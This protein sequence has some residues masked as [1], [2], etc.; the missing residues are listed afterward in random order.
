MALDGIVVADLVSELKSKLV[1]GRIM[2]ISQPER[3]ELVLTIKN[4]EQYKL[5]LSAGAGLP[6]VYITEESKPSPLQAP[7]F[8][9]LLRKYLNSARIMDIYQPGLERIIN[10][11]IEHLDELSDVKEKLLVIELMGKHSNIIFVDDQGK[12]VDSIK[13]VSGFVSSQRE[14]LPGREYF[15]VET[16]KKLDMAA[17]SFEEF[18]SSF[19]AM[20]QP[21]GKALVNCFTG[22]S[23]AVAAEIAYRADIDADD[24]VASLSP[25]ARIHLFKT[26]KFVS[27]DIAAG[28]FFTQIIYKDGVPVDFS[29]V[30]MT[31]MNC[32]GYEK[33]ILDSPSKM[34]HKFYAKKDTTVRIR[35]K[36]SDLRRII[37][38]AIERAAKKYDIQSK[39]LK[40][41]EKRDKYKEYGELLTTYGYSALPG[42]KKLV[43]TSFYTGEEVSI[44]LDETLSAI[45]NA[46]RY[47]D[48]YSKQKRT[49]EATSRMI[50]VTKEEMEHLDSIRTALDIALSEEDLAEIK[51]ELIDF[52]YMKR[53]ILPGKKG[54]K[55]VKITSKPFHF[56]S[57]DGFD[58]YVGKNNYQNEELTFKF[59]KGGDMWFHAKGIPGSHVVVRTDGSELPDRAYEEAGR[60]AAYFSKGRDAEKVEIDYLERKNVKKPSGSKPGFVVY[61][62]NYSLMAKPDISGI[63]EI[64]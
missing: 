10:I 23:P 39:Q 63:K 31:C 8:C 58:I 62:T 60:I 25:D 54:G 55:K 2:K 35:Q 53:H 6:L 20:P 28:R 24:Q 30:D 29:A 32:E 15:I 47:F 36:S 27:D 3:D 12:I 19:S 34:L 26:L 56:V 52:G 14:V 44:P 57:T 21:V 42:A 22:L 13:H 11:R 41:T 59:A 45:E 18:D 40:D 46:K 4:Y 64:K 49:F 1:G 5:L 17:A 38:N 9:M 16:V 51:E 33:E 48:K 7:N 61:Y 50:E 37:L 43:C